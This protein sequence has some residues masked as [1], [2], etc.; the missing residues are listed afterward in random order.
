MQH[1]TM[2]HNVTK[3]IFFETFRSNQNNFLCKKLRFF[4]QQGTMSSAQEITNFFHP[5]K[6][7]IG[8]HK[9]NSNLDHQG[10]NLLSPTDEDNPKVKKEPR[11]R[12]ASSASSKPRGNNDEINKKYRKMSHKEH[13][14]ER[15]GMYTGSVEMTSNLMWVPNMQSVGNPKTLEEK[16][17]EYVPALL[18]LCDELLTNVYDSYTRENIRKGLENSARVTTRQ[19]MVSELHVSLDIEKNLLTVYNNGRG[20]DIEVHETGVYVPELIFGQLLTSTNYENDDE[21]RMAGVNGLGAK[22]CNIFSRSFRVTTVDHER[23]RRYTQLFRNNMECVELPTIENNYKGSPFTEIQM[24]VDFSKFPLEK[25]TEELN[26]LIYRRVY[27]MAVLMPRVNVTWNG[28]AIKIL[29]FHDFTKLF[30]TKTEEEGNSMVDEIAT[31]SSPDRMWQV[32]ARVSDTGFNSVSYV[33]GICTYKGGKHV[34][35]IVTQIANRVIA[36]IKKSEKL[37]IKHSMVK[38]NIF[39]FVSAQ[40]TNPKFDSQ[41]K[42]YC[43][44]SVAQFGSTFNLSNDFFKQLRKAGLYK[45]VIDT[46]EFKGKSKEKKDA[47]KKK[48]SV[49]HIPKLDDANEAGGPRSAECALILTEGDSAKSMAIAGL[50]VVGR[51]LYG[52]F[53]LRGKLLNIREKRE[54][55]TGRDQIKNNQE[56]KYVTEILGLVKGKKYDSLNQLR[57]GRVILM[58]DQDVDGSHIKGLFMNF[59]ETEW[60]ELSDL[61][62]LTCMLTPIIKATRKGSKD[63]SNALSFYSIPAF[64]QWQSGMRAMEAASL[65]ITE[66]EIIATLPIRGYNIKYYKGLGTSTVS[67]ARDYFHDMHLVEYVPT[68]EGREKVDLVFNGKR[69]DDRKQ[70]LRGYDRNLNIHADQTKVPFEEFIDAEYSHYSIYDNQRSIPNVIDGLKPSERKILYACFRRNL[71]TDIKVAQLSGYVSENAAYHH[72]EASLQ[73]T[74]IAMAQNF[75]GSNNMELLIPQGQFGSRLNGGKDN[76]SARYIFTRLSPLTNLIFPSQDRPLLN[77]L[78]DDGQKIEPKYYVPILPMILINGCKGIGTGWSTDVPSFHPLQVADQLLLKIRGVQ[79][80]FQNMLPFFA[81]FRGSIIQ[82]DTNRY[83]TKGIYELMSH[84]TIRITELP[85]GVWTENYKEFLMEKLL[86]GYVPPTGSVKAKKLAEKQNS[87]EKAAKKSKSKA[88]LSDTAL[89]STGATEERFV[90]DIKTQCTESVVF[91]ELKVDPLILQK[92]VEQ[93]PGSASTDNGPNI[94]ER[95][96]NLTSTISMTNM[97]LFD[98]KEV[99]TKYNNV[100]EIMETFYDVRHALYIERRNYI[101]AELQS[102]LVLRTEKVRFIRLI[103]DGLLNPKDYDE[104]GLD[105]LLETKFQFRKRGSGPFG[106]IGNPTFHYLTHM[107]MHSLTKSTIAR[108]EAE[109]E[110]QAI[111]LDML[112]K[113]TALDIWDEELMLFKEAYEKQLEARCLELTKQRESIF[114]GNFGSGRNK[115]KSKSINPKVGSTAVKSSGKK[116]SAPSKASLLAKKKYGTTPNK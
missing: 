31:D 26:L 30:R 97:H 34:D 28:D 70:W 99:I 116:K 96:L 40:L 4:L 36:D 17:C 10:N 22:L 37:D 63:T 102:E 75:V 90:L 80:T 110:K 20:I 111:E 38:E 51:D 60:P 47:T 94:F 57:Y 8:N 83:L 39:V 33:N 112:T 19:L 24:E 91:F 88:L 82:I 115:N 77:Y 74:I 72:G 1:L 55:V 27:D 98:D 35:Y 65:G 23:K 62:F 100:Q 58:T 21:A 89:T 41:S 25:W 92:F 48:S 14:L 9:E 78:E 15:P 64:E 108:L 69:A 87:N 2:F 86:V 68:D 114:S 66:K 81:G 53:P 106:T 79:D 73:T 93:L 54:S 6:P 107:P 11:K 42:E 45:R 67:E 3:Y 50:S 95:K 56:L 76:A 16:E 61:G 13:I 103:I 85:I 32:S 49:L 29:N 113:K 71:T 18:K 44:S 101:L 59:I 109:R 12:P 104:E 46:Y 5:E 52:V 43:S 105:N 84:D 7:V